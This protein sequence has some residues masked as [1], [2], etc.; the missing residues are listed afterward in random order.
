VPSFRG[1]VSN[2]PPSLSL[3]VCAR[4]RARVCVTLTTFLT[5]VTMIYFT[6]NNN[7]LATDF[8]YLACQTLGY[9]LPM[10]ER[11]TL[12]AFINAATH[13]LQY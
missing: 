9:V 3:C 12:D 6:Q 4:A 11:L 7:L 10:I 13:H 8:T 1:N 5:T 2:P